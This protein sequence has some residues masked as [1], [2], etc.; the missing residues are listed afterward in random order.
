MSA[1]AASSSTTFSPTC[2]PSAIR[3]R[4]QRVAARRWSA[5]PGRLGVLG[6]YCHRWFRQRPDERLR[7]SWVPWRLGDGLRHAS[8]SLPSDQWL[9]LS[10]RQSPFSAA[11]PTL[12]GDRNSDLSLSIH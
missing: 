4:R 6:L 8:I 3:A 12:G 11:F 7:A 10:K 1:T 5:Q 2:R 9:V